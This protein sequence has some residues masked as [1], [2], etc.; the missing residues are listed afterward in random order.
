MNKYL[1]RSIAGVF[2][3]LSIVIGY[4]YFFEARVVHGVYRCLVA[5]SSLYSCYAG[6]RRTTDFT[7]TT[8]FYGMKYRGN[9][10]NAIDLEVLAIGAYE[11]PELY[12]LRD[13]MQSV[14]SKQGTFLDVGANVGQ[15]SLFMS[16]YATA[17]HAFE[18]YDLVLERFR[19]MKNLN[20][21]ENIVIHPVGLGNKNQRLPFYEP[22]ADNLGAGSFVTGSNPSVGRSVE[23]EIVVGDDLLENA[24]VSAVN[25]I[26]M[27]IEG[28][29]PFAL[30]GLSRTLAKNRPIVVFEVTVAPGK[31]FGF[32][33]ES[34]MR[35][36]SP[37]TIGFSCSMKGVTSIRDTIT[38]VQS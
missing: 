16:R 4:L 13:V 20:K 5:T 28:Y 11:K 38:R 26:K 37:R 7:F 29:E 34:Q 9:I 17:V 30:Q 14:Y 2:L 35:S 22:P 31:P 27:D 24:N 12:F 6:F 8:D 23:L 19:L 36:V 21:A 32:Q 3:I 15:H 18:P 25:L 33:S 10:G 1:R